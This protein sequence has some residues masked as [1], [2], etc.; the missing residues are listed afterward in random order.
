[1]TMGELLSGGEPFDNSH[2]IGGAVMSLMMLAGLVYYH[3]DA[4]ATRLEQ[5]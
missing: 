5:R 1:M 4:K 3:L 2:I